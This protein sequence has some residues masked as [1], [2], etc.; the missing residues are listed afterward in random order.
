MKK[1]FI[2]TIIFLSNLTFLKADI[3]I[4]SIIVGK[5]SSKVNIIVYESL[6]CSYCANFHKQ[7]YPKLKKDYI[8]KGLVRIEFRSFP[9]DMAA[10]NA[11]KIAHCKNDGK[12]EILHFLF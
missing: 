9:L 5:E 1:I 2:L 7:I 11:S 4:N 6:T 3:K 12:S 10:L 8:D